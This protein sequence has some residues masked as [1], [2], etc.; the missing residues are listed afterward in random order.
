VTRNSIRGLR[1]SYALFVLE[2]DNVSG[3]VKN[4]CGFEPISFYIALCSAIP[5]NTRRKPPLDCGVFIG[6]GED[7]VVQC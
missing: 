4:C 5:F 7:P 3:R 6:S 2:T 1:P